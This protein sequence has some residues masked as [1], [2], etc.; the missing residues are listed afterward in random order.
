MPALIAIGLSVGILAGIWTSVSI[1][2]QLVTFAAFLAWASYFAAG[3][4]VKGLRDSLLCNFSG[5]VYGF[6]IIQFSGL[7][8]PSVGDAIGLGISLGV[9]AMFMC[10]QAKLSF[11]GFIPGTFIGCATFF[12]TGLDFTGS[13]IGLVLGALLGHASQLGGNLFTKVTAPPQY[14]AQVQ[15]SAEEIK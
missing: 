14:Q 7:I 5:V 15:T 1:I 11:L 6:L 10:W 12:A 4:G 3:G 13:V 9:L 8:S 2:G